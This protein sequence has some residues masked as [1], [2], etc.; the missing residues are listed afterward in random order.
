MNSPYCNVVLMVFITSSNS[1][2]GG[3]ISIP[4]IM[5]Q[6]KTVPVLL[7][8]LH[9]ES[10]SYVISFHCNSF[11]NRFHI[12]LIETV[13]SLNRKYVLC[14]P[15][16]FRLKTELIVTSSHI[17]ATIF[18]LLLKVLFFSRMC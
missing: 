10:I 13:T 3:L 17:L 6:K 18:L 9:L 5:P 2:Q 1:C 15:F 14:S 11:N 16:H 12:S 7:F 4:H 8:L